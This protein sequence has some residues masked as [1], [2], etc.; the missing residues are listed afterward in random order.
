[1]IATYFV[2]LLILC[3]ASLFLLHLALAL[4]SLYL[5]PRFA[6]PS[7]PR[8]LNGLPEYRSL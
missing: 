6:E 1:M 3:F 5:F 4:L 8:R 2:R 7:P